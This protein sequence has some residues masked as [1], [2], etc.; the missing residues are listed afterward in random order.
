MA[1]R[2]FPRTG[3]HAGLSCTALALLLLASPALAQTQIDASRPPPQTSGVPIPKGQ[4]ESAV[5]KV[6]ALARDLMTRSG[7]PGLAVAVVHEGKT[8]FLKGYGVR[9]VGESAAIDADTVFQLASLSKSVGSSVVA[10]EVGKGTVKWDTPVED[11]LPW[12]ALNDDWVSE[13]VTIADLYSHRSGLP[14]HAGDELEDLGYDRR[15]VL[16]RLKKLPLAPFRVSY[17]YTNFGVTAA[18]EAVATASG[19]DW[20]TLS[21]EVLYKPLGM[22]S[23][24]SRFSDYMAR[25]NRA[26]PHVRVGKIGESKT[27]AAKFQRD[28]QAQSP[29]GGVSSSVRDMA[30]WLG[31]VLGGGSYEGRQI[32]PEKALLPAMRPEMISSPA[33]AADARAGFYGYGFGVNVSPAGRVMIDHSG[34]FILGAGTTYVLLPSEKLGIVVLTNAQPTGVP[35]ALAASFMDL[36]QFGTVTRDWL[37]AYGPLIDPL[38]TPLGTLA[39]K[40]APARPT[41][42]KPLATYVGTYAN[43]YFGEARVSEDKGHL[44]LT[45]GPKPRV[46]TLDH[47][48]GDDFIFRPEG[49]ETAPAGSVSQVT[50]SDRRMKVEFFN[51]N[52]LGTFERR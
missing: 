29:A 23:T 40:S 5:G 10:H 37:T 28:P 34:A 14:D 6:D 2:R 43:A 1:H 36:A 49:E 46:F 45:V 8:V 13:H 20:E 19:K 47:W 9:K 26:V 21:E 38:Y 39:G 44:I 41:P 17:A 11:L 15:Q 4:I 25:S 12:F 50:F 42:A 24:S 7:I 16:E 51:N 32:V 35:E 30:R 31:F 3:R 18:A 52:G 48:S 27:F 33:Y 22:A